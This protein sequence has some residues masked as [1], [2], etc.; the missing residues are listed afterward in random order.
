MTIFT[1]RYSTAPHRNFSAWL[2]YI[3]EFYSPAVQNEIF[4]RRRWQRN[5][6]MAAPPTSLI[7]LAKSSQTRRLTDPDEE[8]LKLLAESLGPAGAE[9]MA[10]QL[11]GLAVRAEVVAACSTG[12][13]GT[14]LH[15]LRPLGWHSNLAHRNVRSLLAVIR[16]GWQLLRNWFHPNGLLITILGPIGAGKTTISKKIFDVLGPAFG[17][18]K[19]MMWRP[20]ALPRLSRILPPLTCPIASRPMVRCNRSHDPGYLF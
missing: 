11:F 17:P 3:G 15:K 20:E 19:F 7:S 18:Q 13:L 6:W 4:V 16:K 8:R 9:A 10:G 1:L 2:S 12:T 14:I 5:F